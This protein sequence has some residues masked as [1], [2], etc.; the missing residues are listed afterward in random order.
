MCISYYRYGK[1]TLYYYKISLGL[2]DRNAVL[3]YDWAF[4]RI[5]TQFVRRADVVFKTEKLYF[6][7]YHGN[8]G[9]IIF[10]TSIAIFLPLST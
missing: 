8:Q 7:Q 6:R 3:G 1:N 2:K 10:T 4:Q 5:L 9:P